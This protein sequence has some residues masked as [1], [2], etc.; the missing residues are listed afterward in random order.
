MTDSFLI[1][2]LPGSSNIVHATLTDADSSILT[3]GNV[4]VR[5]WPGEQFDASTAAPDGNST[6][7][8]LYIDRVS[9]LI[10]RLRQSGGKTV[11]ARRISGAFRSFD[12]KAMIQEYFT[13]FPDMFCFAFY[14]PTTG[15]WMGASP[16]LL[17]RYDAS[18]GRVE[19]QAL[20]GTR[21]RGAD[22]T[23]SDK[24]VAEHLM[25]VDD[26]AERISIVADVT[27]MSMSP[28]TT[29]SY[30][31]IEHLC[32]PIAVTGLTPEA[33]VYIENALHPTAAVGGYPRARAYAD[34]RAIEDAPRRCYGGLISLNDP[35]GNRTTYVVLRCVHFDSHR[36]EIYTGSGITADSDADDEWNETATKAAPLIQLLSH[37]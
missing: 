14:H 36:W 7:Q 28:H 29:L 26:M 16:E 5:P 9:T 10:D 13:L 30:G 2:R 19:T 8:S 15:Y 24:N 31:N 22:K 20:A 27:Y 34:I 17:I 32:T 25:V 6:S 12:L 18:T 1:Y 23:W 11:I 35:G 4:T 37:Y 33:A 3:F 21:L